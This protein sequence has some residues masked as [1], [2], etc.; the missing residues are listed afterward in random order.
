[1]ELKHRVNACIYSSLR[2]INR[3]FMELKLWMD[4]LLQG[5]SESINRTFM[6]LK[7]HSIAHVAPS[8]WY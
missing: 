5:R 6:E 1:M 4:V 8:G 7:L 3:T 2:G